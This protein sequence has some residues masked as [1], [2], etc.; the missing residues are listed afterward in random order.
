MTYNGTST[1]RE[2]KQKLRM[3][4]KCHVYSLTERKGEN[5]ELTNKDTY[6][7]TALKKG[8]INTLKYIYNEASTALERG[9]KII[10]RIIG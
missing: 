5:L 4:S 2:D 1:D 6:T 3:D 7:C 9:H 8:Q 10:A